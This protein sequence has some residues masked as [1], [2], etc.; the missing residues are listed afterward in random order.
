ME[1]LEVRVAILQNLGTLRDLGI[2]GDDLSWEGRSEAC[3]PTRPRADILPADEFMRL[4]PY[5][6]RSDNDVCL[7]RPPILEPHAGLLCVLEELRDAT[8]ALDLDADALEL[9]DEHLQKL[10]P[11]VEVKPTGWI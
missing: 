5:A 9:R 7:D 11:M 10:G 6:V 2:V 3:Q 8:A 4:S 1:Q